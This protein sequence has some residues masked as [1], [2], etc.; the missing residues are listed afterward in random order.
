MDEPTGGPVRVKLGTDVRWLLIFP[1]GDIAKGMGPEPTLGRLVREAT[2]AAFLHPRGMLLYAAS[3]TDI[4]WTVDQVIAGPGV[5][6]SVRRWGFSIR[7]REGSRLWWDPSGVMGI[8]PTVESIEQV[9]GVVSR[10]LAS[11]LTE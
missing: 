9:R 8:G 10:H 1:S 2:G 7:V 11:W 5:G 6:G 4:L 3:A